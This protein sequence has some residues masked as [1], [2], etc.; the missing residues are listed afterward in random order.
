MRCFSI[1]KPL[2]AGRRGSRAQALRR[3]FDETLADPALVAGAETSRCWT[4]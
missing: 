1:I 3:A 2:A 4:A